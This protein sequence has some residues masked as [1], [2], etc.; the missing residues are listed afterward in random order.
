MKRSDLQLI[1]D[2]LDGTISPR[3]LEVL[4]EL[5]ESDAT[6]RE[7]FLSLATMDEGLQDLAVTPSIVTDCTGYNGGVYPV[8]S[9]SVQG[10]VGGTRALLSRPIVAAAAGLIL[11]VFFT[12]AIWAATETG[13]QKI[14][15]LF[16]DS[17]E[18]GSPPVPVG[19]PVN[20]DAWGGDYVEISGATSGIEPIHGERMLRFLR[21]DYEGKE[22]AVGYMSDI[23]RVIDL[24][25]YS[26]R[27]ADGNSVVAVEADFGSVP[28]DDADRFFANLSVY[29]L[30]QVP[31]NTQSW[32]VLIGTPRRMEE[33][34]LASARRS[35]GLEGS[36]G[37]SWQ[38]LSLEMRLPQETNYLL[39][40]LHTGDR[41]AAGESGSETPPAVQFE[42]QFVDDV[43]VKLRRG[44]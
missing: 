1:E 42:G 34:A 19:G 6:A 36:P 27:F 13:R 28:L 44:I 21:A 18:F 41:L 11:G 23:Y 43:K 4:N 16:H 10:T 32:Q 30:A 25:K 20:P 5:L 24:K 35:R 40:G 22:D 9:G 29:A 8:R 33:V 31:T 17:F 26:S 14:L 38:K 12:S 7:R 3:D 2:Y 15:T 39:I 37:M